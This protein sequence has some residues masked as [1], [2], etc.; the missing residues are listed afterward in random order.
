M[1]R[2]T[3]ALS[4]IAAALVSA[5]MAWQYPRMPSWE[6]IKSTLGSDLSVSVIIAAQPHL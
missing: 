6:T 3:V 2:R 4:A 5:A 1:S